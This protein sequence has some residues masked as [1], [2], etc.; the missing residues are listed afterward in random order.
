MRIAE[1]GIPH[2]AGGEMTN[3]KLREKCEAVV[4]KHH[5]LKCDCIEVADACL[6]LLEANRWHR[7]RDERP[8]E[9]IDGMVMAQVGRESWWFRL[10]PLPE[11]PEERK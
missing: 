9:V 8:P 3:E 7:T 4:L 11:S 10:P 1:I 2:I 6:A 5:N